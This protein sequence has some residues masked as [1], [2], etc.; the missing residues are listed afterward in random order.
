[1]A[2]RDALTSLP[3][4]QYLLEKLDSIIHR[5][6]E[7]RESPQDAVLFLDLDNF[8]IINDSLGHDAGDALL[9]QVASRLKECV[10]EYDTSLRVCD[11]EGQTVRLGGDEFVVL[12][13]KLADSSHALRVADRIVKRISEPFRL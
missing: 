13:E 7:R 9:N 4:R 6:G 8:K 1:M 10:R 2:H 5:H 12:L 11:Q 3:N